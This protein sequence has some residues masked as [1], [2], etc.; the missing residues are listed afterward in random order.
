MRPLLQELGSQQVSGSVHGSGRA[1]KVVSRGVQSSPRGAPHWPRAH[2]ASTLRTP[3]PRPRPSPPARRLAPPLPAPLGPPPLPPAG[4]AAWE[5]RALGARGAGRAGR[6]L[7]AVHT[8]LQLSGAR[9]AS[10]RR[11]RRPGTGRQSERFVRTP[12]RDSARRRQPRRV[13]ASASAPGRAGLAAVGGAR[14]RARV[15]AGAGAGGERRAAEAAGAPGAGPGEPRALGKTRMMNK[16]YI[17][18]LSP[19]VTADDLRQ[20]FGDRKLPLA[21]QVLLKSGYAFVDYPDQNWA[22]R[23]IETLSGEHSRC[24]RRASPA[25]DAGSGEAEPH[26]PRPPRLPSPHAHFH[27]PVPRDSRGGLAPEWPAALPPLR[28]LTDPRASESG[29]PCAPLRVPRLAGSLGA[30][31]ECPV[32]LWSV[33][34]PPPL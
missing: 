20:L 5:L 15:G 12:A 17:G 27:A 31:L 32:A 34:P 28:G 23:A 30:P 6:A 18:N 22:I 1:G 29:R 3:R 8:P 21:G 9:G 19:A 14:L 24:P 10:A 11:C 33:P 16:L 13:P 25:R 7:S 4:R 2:V 26:G